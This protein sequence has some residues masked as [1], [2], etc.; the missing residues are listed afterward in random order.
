MSTLVYS[1]TDGA[2]KIWNGT[3]L[4]DA[5]GVKYVT[6]TITI[7]AKDGENYTALGNSS[8]YIKIH[9]GNSKV[10]IGAA[11]NGNG[12]VGATADLN[13]KFTFDNAAS[14]IS[15]TTTF[16]LSVT[17]TYAESADNQYNEGSVDTATSIA[18]GDWTF[19]V[20]AAK[21]GSTTDLSDF[22]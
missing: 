14:L 11:L 20:S 17:P 15:K 4:V 1:T 13:A 19:T 21:P 18:P 6:C 12:V 16:K 22:A 8:Y 9:N 5:I 2:A 3:H 10:R 7:S